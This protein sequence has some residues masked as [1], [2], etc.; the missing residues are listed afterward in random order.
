MRCFEWGG[1]HRSVSPVG[2][3]VGRLTA[4][5]M[6]A[7]GEKHASGSRIE[8]IELPRMEKEVEEEEVKEVEKEEVKKKKEEEDDE[9]EGDR[10]FCANMLSTFIR[11]LESQQWESLRERMREPVRHS[12]HGLTY[13]YIYIF[14][15]IYVGRVICDCVLP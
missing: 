11:G 13:H 4:N 1:H 8:G 6:E 15:Y 9:Q 12:Q 14:I 5:N 10:D 3:S 7:S 2:Q